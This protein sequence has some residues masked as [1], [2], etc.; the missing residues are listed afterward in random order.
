MPEGLVSETI[1]FVQPMDAST[2]PAQQSELFRLLRRRGAGV[3]WLH[4]TSGLITIASGIAGND[5]FLVLYGTL[6]LFDQALF[7]ADLFSFSNPIGHC[8]KGQ[9]PKSKYELRRKLSLSVFLNL[10]IKTSKKHSAPAEH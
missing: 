10:G 7:R 1:G 4:K 3:H 6:R 2:P 5:M 8:P 9:F